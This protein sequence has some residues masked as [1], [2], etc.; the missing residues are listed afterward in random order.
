MNRTYIFIAIAVVVAILVVVYLYNGVSQA[1]QYNNI[2]GNL[3][4]RPAGKITLYYATWCGHS[5]QFMPEWEK[6]VKYANQHMPYIQV[7]KIECTKDNKEACSVVRGFP[8]VILINHG[9]QDFIITPGMRVAQ[10]VLTSVIQAK[11]LVADALAVTAR[12]SG[13]FGHTGTH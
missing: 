9:K 5:K 13:G 12:G 4:V 7:N 2:R 8:S 3:P 11:F 1:E 10:C 6:F